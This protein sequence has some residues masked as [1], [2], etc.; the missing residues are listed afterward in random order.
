M[1]QPSPAGPNQPDRS[2]IRCVSPELLRSR[3]IPPR[4]TL[5][6]TVLGTVCPL[7]GLRL[8]AF[9]TLLSGGVG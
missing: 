4:P 3:T 2:T 7:F 1:S 8:L 6:S 5:A 9:G